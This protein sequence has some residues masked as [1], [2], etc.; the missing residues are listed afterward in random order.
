MA[1]YSQQTIDN[2]GNFGTAMEIG[3]TFTGL[4]NNYF[5]G[6]TEKYNLQTQGLNFLHHLDQKLLFAMLKVMSANRCYMASL[7]EQH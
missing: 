1:K 4:V 2:I 6:E 5:A 3:G 7:Y